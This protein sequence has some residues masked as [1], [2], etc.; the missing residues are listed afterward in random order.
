MMPQSARIADVKRPQRSRG[1]IQSYRNFWLQ[2]KDAS[3]SSNY[4][5]AIESHDHNR[6]NVQVHSM[7][8]QSRTA[9]WALPLSAILSTPPV[10][11]CFGPRCEPRRPKYIKH[12]L[13]NTALSS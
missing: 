6:R 11:H 9:E 13:T 4:T 5:V 12:L 7:F 8:M 1:Q 2:L 3:P 10:R